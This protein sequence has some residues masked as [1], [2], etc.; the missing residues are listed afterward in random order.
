[1]LNGGSDWKIGHE[2][3]FES[4][5]GERQKFGIAEKRLKVATNFTSCPVSEYKNS[6]KTENK[7]HS[8]VVCT[9]SVSLV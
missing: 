7:L 1:M 6:S 2:Y 8:R 3:S 9:L 5:K 4:L